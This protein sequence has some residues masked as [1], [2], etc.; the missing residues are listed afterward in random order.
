M[1]T[2]W[3]S[4]DLGT[5]KTWK[6]KKELKPNKNR[7]PLSI[8]RETPNRR[9]QASRRRSDGSPNCGADLPNERKS[10]R[11]EKAPVAKALLGVCVISLFS[12][13]GDFLEFLY[14]CFTGFWLVCF[15]CVKW[16]HGG[17][18]TGLMVSYSVFYFFSQS[19][20]CLSEYPKSFCNMILLHRQ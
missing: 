12:V 15:A 6:T 16:I 13:F 8:G 1:L 14:R 11:G 10:A 19:H 4:F 20:L 7:T 18:A 9:S 5:P 3:C 2:C 17:L